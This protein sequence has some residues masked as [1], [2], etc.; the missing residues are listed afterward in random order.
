MICNEAFP[1]K[2]KKKENGHHR[3]IK[4]GER[5]WRARAN[6]TRERSFREVMNNFKCQLSVTAFPLA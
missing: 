6:I 4:A 1:E 3:K 5:L 2:S